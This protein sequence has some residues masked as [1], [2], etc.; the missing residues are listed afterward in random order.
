MTHN[1][2]TRA[3][4]G[5]SGGKFERSFSGTSPTFQLCRL[6]KKYLILAKGDRVCKGDGTTASGNG[7][8]SSSSKRCYSSQLL[9][10]KTDFIYV[11]Q[12]EL[13]SSRWIQD[14]NH[15]QLE[16]TIDVVVVVKG[17]RRSTQSPKETKRWE[18]EKC[19]NYV[20]VGL[21]FDQLSK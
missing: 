12:N 10:K 13:D 20:L 9:L 14:R 16:P 15:V 4:T 18:E 17:R 1:N 19:A 11:I 5:F 21:M 6:S 7:R 2:R 3:K 8:F